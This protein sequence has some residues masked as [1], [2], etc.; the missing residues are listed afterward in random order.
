MSPDGKALL[1]GS[2]EAWAQAAVAAGEDPDA[3]HAAARRTAA[4]YTGEPDEPA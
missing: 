4:F 3:A 1:T 2:S